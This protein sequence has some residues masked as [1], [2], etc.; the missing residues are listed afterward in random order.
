MVPGHLDSSQCKEVMVRLLSHG[1][2]EIRDWSQAGEGIKVPN[3]SR[4]RAICILE[5]LSQSLQELEAV[6]HRPPLASRSST[7]VRGPSRGSSIVFEAS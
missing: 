6:T 3:C 4:F 7:A 2:Q 5:H 1:L